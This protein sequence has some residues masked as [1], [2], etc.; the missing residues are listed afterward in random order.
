MCVWVCP[1]NMKYNDVNS[2]TKVQWCAYAN[3]FS[4]TLT[5]C[6][7]PLNDACPNTASIPLGVAFDEVVSTAQNESSW[8]FFHTIQWKKTY[9]FQLSA[10]IFENYT[11]RLQSHVERCRRLNSTPERRHTLHIFAD[12]EWFE[13][14]S[15]D[16]YLQHYHE[17]NPLCAT[18]TSPGFAP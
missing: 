3:T 17:T 4:F 9:D 18:E 15:I 7:I 8:F 11:A 10:L 6:I 2:I 12:L 13:T 1:L 5:W 14:H 16:R